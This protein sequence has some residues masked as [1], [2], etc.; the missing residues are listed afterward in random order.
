[1]FHALISWYTHIDPVN[2]WIYL[3]QFI[4]PVGLIANY[5]FAK[6]LFVNHRS[7]IVY[8]FIY[9]FYYA[10]Y[11]IEPPAEGY[12][13]FHSEHSACNNFLAIGIFMPVILNAV[14]DYCRYED[15][16]MLFFLPLL[17]FADGFIHLYVQTKTY[18]VLY[19]ICMFSFFIR[20]DF[21]DYRKIIK[22]T[23]LS[24][25]GLIFFVYVFLLVS[26]KIVNPA[27]LNVNGGLPMVHFDKWLLVDY[28]HAIFRNG[29]LLT[30]FMI[31]FVSIFYIRSRLSGFFIFSIFFSVCFI[32]FNPLI[33]YLGGKFHPSYE[34]ITR[35]YNV[36]PFC[37]SV[38]FPFELFFSGKNRIIN[39][40]L[41]LVSITAVMYT[42]KD[43]KKRLDNIVF[44]KQYS[45][46]QLHNN[47]AFYKN[48]RSKVPHGSTVMMDLSL[49]TWW[50]T[51][52]SHYIIAHAFDMHVPPNF[53]QGDRKEDVKMF[54][55]DPLSPKSMEI[56][57]KYGV[58]YVIFTSEGVK[59]RVSH[60]KSVFV[61][62]R[63]SIYKVDK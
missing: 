10:V 17:F 46:T 16:R 36:I 1:M 59:D 7:P 2:I 42:S 24:S 27:Y 49:T 56:L 38:T 43:V 55:N 32:L 14:F 54:Y 57:K 28:H 12:A 13:W 39:Y 8:L 34:R 25:I 4:L 26:G 60:L 45:L 41:V 11:N 58:E 22:A 44:T 6:R 61:S 3:P 5:Y 29:M 30:S 37:L 33:L 21:I 50:T 40:I 20:P 52:F 18:F 23:L 19:S 31:F 48:V 63:F 51:Y 47:D 35:L 9:F 15:N 53:Y 62:S